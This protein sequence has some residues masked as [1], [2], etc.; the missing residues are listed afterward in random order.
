MKRIAFSLA[1][2]VPLV[3][4]FGAPSLAGCSVQKG[5]EGERAATVSLESV[6]KNPKDYL[7]KRV[8]LTG[9]LENEGKNLFTDMRIVLKDAEGNSIHVRPWLPVSLPPLPPG[10]T[11]QRPS[12]MSEFLGKQVELDAVVA[13]GTIKKLGEVYLLE[14]HSAKVLK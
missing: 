10:H 5:E 6:A 2:L 3:C 12:T 13:R 9:R 14:V 7:G 8:R 4:A 1:A 11:G